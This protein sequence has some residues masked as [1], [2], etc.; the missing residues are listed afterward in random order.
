MT[1]YVVDRI[2]EGFALLEVEK[3]GVCR[4]EKIRLELL[5]SGVKEGDLLCRDEDTGEWRIDHE[6]TEAARKA[7]FRLQ[8]SLF[9]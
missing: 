7:N 1:R 4:M 6:A 9:E 5:P 8:Q 3:D 2:E